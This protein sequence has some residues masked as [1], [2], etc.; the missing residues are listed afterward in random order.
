MKGGLHFEVDAKSQH[1]PFQNLRI[2]K[3][4]IKQHFIKSIMEFMRAVIKPFNELRTCLELRNN[5]I[6]FLFY[7]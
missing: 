7:F 1:E 3:L 4:F 6:T 5:K 2:W